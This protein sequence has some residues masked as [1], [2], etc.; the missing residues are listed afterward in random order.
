M[1]TR[2][3]SFAGAACFPLVLSLLA[4]AARADE[5]VQRPPHEH[6]KVTINAALDGNELVIEL[7][8]PAV[9]VVGFE[10]EPRTDEERAAVRAAAILLGNGRELFS[11][12]R[13]ARCQFGKTELKAPEWEQSDDDEAAPHDEHEHHAD[14]HARFTYRCASPDHL[15]WLQPALLDKLR[16]VTEAR[17][18]IATATGQRSEVVTNGRARVALR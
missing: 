12:P 13:E 18:N 5:F 6:G 16:S 14:Y 7:D 3:F 17:I 1:N 11:M 10:H 4:T 9:N 2:P 8:S 15:M